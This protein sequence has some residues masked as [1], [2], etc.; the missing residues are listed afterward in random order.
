[1]HYPENLHAEHSGV[2][3][4]LPYNLQMFTRDAIIIY[5]YIDIMSRHALANTK[6]NNNDIL[7]VTNYSRGP[8][9]GRGMC[10]TIRT[11]DIQV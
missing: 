8:K 7:I 1:M 2:T 11:L 4:P 6:A 3:F 9:Y 10:L 5:A